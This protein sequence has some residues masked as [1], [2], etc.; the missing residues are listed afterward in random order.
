MSDIKPAY[1]GELMLLG[2]AQTHSAGAKVTFL[3][4]DDEALEA[5]RH[6]TVKKGSTAGQR[7]M[8]VLV[9]INEQDEPITPG[10][11]TARSKKDSLTMSAVLLCKSEDFQK[12]VASKVGYLP[13]LPHDRD[14][15][16]AKYI[17]TFCRIDSRKELDTSPT[18]AHLFAQLM[19]DYRNWLSPSFG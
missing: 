11:D 7:F 3:L 8:A 15:Q 19:A 6:L 16:S 12:F 5:F 2:W 14:E 18:A 13:A 4:P 10:T 17:K 1:Q 9:Q